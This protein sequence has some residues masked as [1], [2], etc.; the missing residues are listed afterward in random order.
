MFLRVTPE[1]L[2]ATQFEVVR[3]GYADLNAMNLAMAPDGSV[4]VEESVGDRE[5]DKQQPVMCRLP[6]TGKLACFSVP[7]FG[8]FVSFD[9]IVAQAGGVVFILADT[10]LTRIDLPQ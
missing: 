8:E 10:T 9:Q 4:Y 7:K 2:T 6:E 3:E 5:I 1:N